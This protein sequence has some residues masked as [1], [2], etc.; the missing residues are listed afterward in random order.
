MSFRQMRVLIMFDLPVVSSSERRDYTRFRKYL[1]KS[2][3]LMLQ[4]S[5]YCKLVMNA[6]SANQLIENIKKNKPSNGNVICLKITEK[7]FSKMEY[8]V[9]EK[10]SDVLDSTE[11]V[12]IL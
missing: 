6:V 1:I 2:G 10:I 7:Q 12:V 11:R 4:E 8:I 3:F 5:I 9:G